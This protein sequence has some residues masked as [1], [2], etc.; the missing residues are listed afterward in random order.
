MLSRYLLY[1]GV[2]VVERG[3]DEHRGGG[4]GGGVVGV[5]GPL[6]ERAHLHVGHGGRVVDGDPVLLPRAVFAA[7][8]P[9]LGLGDHT[10]WCLDQPPEQLPVE[11]LAERAADQVQSDGVDARVAVAQTESDDAQ[12]VP[13]CVVVVLRPWVQV[14]PQHERV[15]G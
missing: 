12:N 2:G 13:E 10:A 3:A 1:D 5:H 14:E 9:V 15:I 8:V 11:V 7:H 4:R 6:G